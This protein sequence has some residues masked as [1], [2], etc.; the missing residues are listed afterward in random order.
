MMAR[1]PG[2]CVVVVLTIAFGAGLNG[3]VFLAA[4]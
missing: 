3:A 1:S 2:L 4:Q